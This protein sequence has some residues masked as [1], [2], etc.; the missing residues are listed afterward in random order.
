MKKLLIILFCLFS[1]NVFSKSV[2]YTYKALKAEGCSVEYSAT[3]QEGKPYLVVAVTSDRLV[4]PE[5]P[6]LLFRCFDDSIIKLTG[7]SVA[8]SSSQYGIMI[9]NI[10][11]PIS[12]LRVTAIFP[13]T[14][15]QVELLKNGVSKVSLSTLPIKHERSF[16]KDKIG[17]KLHDFFQADKDKENSF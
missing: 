1:L 5:N 17:R 12:E 6:I 4:Y 16:N 9:N 10:M 14:E 8:S 11:A 13:M 3:W 2:K 15:E 7:T